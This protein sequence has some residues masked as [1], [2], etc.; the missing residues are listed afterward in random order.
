MFD[1][2][3]GEGSNGGNAANFFQITIKMALKAA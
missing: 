2:A 3:Y 1:G